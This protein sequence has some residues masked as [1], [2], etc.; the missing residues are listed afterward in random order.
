MGTILVVDDDEKINRMLTLI[1]RRKGFDVIKAGDAPSA[2][3][4]LRSG[5]RIDL[6]LLDINMPGVQGD[7]LNEILQ[8]FHYKTRVMVCSV[9]PVEEQAKRIPGA[10]DYYDKAE[11]F[12][13]LIG[14]VT[15]ILGPGQSVKLPA[16]VENRIKG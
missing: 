1:L 7:E 6:V 3:E 5:R 9:F 2:H 4:V 16:G 10:T 14:K 11:S 12:S 8:S 15:G 13:V